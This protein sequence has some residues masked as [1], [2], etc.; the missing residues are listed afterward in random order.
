MYNYFLNEKQRKLQELKHQ[1]EEKYKQ[2]ESI[3][4]SK[5]KWFLLENL[6]VLVSNYENRIKNF[7]FEMA[8]SPIKIKNY[9]NPDQ[10]TRKIFFDGSHGNKDF[11]LHVNYKS[12]KER[13]VHQL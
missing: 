8:S 4:K 7:I 3:R 12:E 6:P 10:N 1:N 13:I 5:I 11:Q 9:I 2:L